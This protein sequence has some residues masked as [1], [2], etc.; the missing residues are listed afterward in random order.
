MMECQVPVFQ[1]EDRMT[2]WKDQQCQ[3]DGLQQMK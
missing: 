2:A 3:L 1:H